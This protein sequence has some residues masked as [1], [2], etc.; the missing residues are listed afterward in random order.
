M[1]KRLVLILAALALIAGACGGD[2]DDTGGG[3]GGETSTSGE[4]SGV[5]EE[6][7]PKLGYDLV[8]ASTGG[9][10]WDP[11]APT[12][13]GSKELGPQHWVFGGLMRKTA[14]GTL[15][16]DLAESANVVDANT[17]TVVMR[18]GLTLSDGTPLDA[19]M[20]KSILEGNLAK[21]LPDGK[22][23]GAFGAGFY[24]LKTVT[25]DGN[26][27]TLGFPDGS[28]A[29]WF[30]LYL[31]SQETLPVPP[32]TN[33][34]LPVGAGPFVLTENVAGQKM[35]F[36]K[37][38]DYW[39]ADNI[40]VAGIELINVPPDNE[41]AAFGAVNSHQVDWSRLTINGIDAVTAV[42]VVSEPDPQ[43]LFQILICKSE[44]PFDDVLV[45]QALNYAIDREAISTAI[46]KG[47]GTPAWDLW[48][49]GHALH[50]D[51]TT[52]HYA[53]D[54]DKARE[55]LEEAGQE[56]LSV[57]VIPIPSPPSPDIAAVI[58]QQWADVGVEM[59]IVA[60][61][62]FVQD[63][64]TN[65]L[66]P[67]GIIPQSIS[68]RSKLL[69]FTGTGI[70]NPCA[71]SDPE[72]N[73]LVTDIGAVSDTSEEGIQLWHDI[74][75]IWSDDAVAI[76]IVFGPRVFGVDTDRLGGYE[77]MPEAATPVPDMWEL[78]VKA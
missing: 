11:A 43:A 54:P 41:Q 39:D 33:F 18:E 21:L 17:I 22:P 47:A 70:S 30:D 62:A 59:N 5:D 12:S 66:A 61:T 37:N 64:L 67:L 55:L 44:A 16:P 56:S 38:L 45:R 19:T 52:E 60:T 53:Y 58:Q 78:F 1:R 9:F 63:F 28:A 25:V 24:S 72:L 75:Q 10:K 20:M 51:E 74:Q 29:G 15:V 7:I 49:E 50:N 27:L 36:E 34:E 48:P 42:D 2:D 76:P 35:T 46:L 13:A 26:T 32:G 23:I 6:G 3:D 8:S 4:P 77:L 57:D 40:E 14:D 71:Y 65:H 31:S 69:N 68:A 73:E